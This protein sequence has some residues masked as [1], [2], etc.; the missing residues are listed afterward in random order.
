MQNYWRKCST[1]KKE[2]GFKT[3]Y[4]V[5]SVSSCNGKRTGLVF[6]STSCFERHLPFARH[7]DA[8]ALEELSPLKANVE[9]ASTPVST[10]KRRIIASAPTVPGSSIQPS[11][12]VV[13]HDILVVA[14]KLKDYIRARS[15]MNTSASCLT[16][17]S[18]ILRK[19]CDKAI[20]NARADGRKTVMDR[21]FK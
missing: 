17:L 20:E 16:A 18:D 5:C 21:D 13:T 10:P 15:E 7:K 11:H 12:S 3:K 14:S 8:S 9:E 1:C 2:I 6:C 19:E 4:Y